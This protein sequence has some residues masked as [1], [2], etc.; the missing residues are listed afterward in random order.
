MLGARLVR[1]ARNDRCEAC[2]NGVKI[3]LSEIMEYVEEDGF[4]LRHL[5]GG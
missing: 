5:G 2:G 3:K 1:M 4:D